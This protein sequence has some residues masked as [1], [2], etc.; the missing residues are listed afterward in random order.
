MPDGAKHHG[1]FLDLADIALVLA[2]FDIAWG[3]TDADPPELVPTCTP[4]HIA[5]I[6]LPQDLVD[7]GEYVMEPIEPRMVA[8]VEGGIAIICQPFAPRHRAG[9][10]QVA[11][12]PPK[13][14]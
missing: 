3:L 10:G 12:G 2:Q 13:Q 11:D 4:S 1:I 9:D 6:K 14:P 7:T 5:P 8:V